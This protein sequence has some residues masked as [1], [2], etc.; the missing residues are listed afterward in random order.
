MFAIRRSEVTDRDLFTELAMEIEVRH[1]SFGVRF[2]NESLLMK[3]LAV[4]VW[5]VNRRFLSGYI[6]TLGS[7]VYFPSRSHVEDDYKAAFDTLAHEFVHIH[8]SARALPLG[9]LTRWL[10]PQAL[11]IF[12][13]GY[14]FHVFFLLALL[15][16]IPWP[17]PWRC[18]IEARG[19]A[20]NVAT[21]FWRTGRVDPATREWVNWEFRGWGYYRMAWS[22]AVVAERFTHWME[23][24]RAQVMPEA[25]ALPY[26][27]VKQVLS[28][29]G[30]VVPPLKELSRG[31]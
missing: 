31:E 15:A 22:D 30:K 10:L 20:M 9:F 6:T 2:K 7:K 24:L 25:E 5:P 18:D 21:E 1:P 28:A 4:L 11:A 26:E 17:S 14:F 13:L 8:D 3:V 16:L 19:Y 12:A 27:V 29:A 23:R